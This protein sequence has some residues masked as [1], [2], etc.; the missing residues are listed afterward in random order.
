MSQILTKDSRVVFARGFLNTISDG[1]ANVYLTISHV[2]PWANE[3]NPDIPIDTVD[4]QVGL[5]RGMIGGK[6]ITG[7]DIQLVVPRYDWT[8][9]TV[10][11]SYTNSANAS[12]ASIFGS[13]FY[14]LTSDFNVYKCLGN[15]GNANSTVMPTYTAV[16]RSHTESDGYVWKYMLS[17]TTLDRQKFLTTSYFPVRKLLL[18]DG[19]LQWR[20]QGA[21]IAGTVDGVVLTNNGSN[22]TN[23]SNLVVTITGDGSSVTATG[24]INV[25]SQTVNSIT[26][27]SPGSGFHFANVSIT[28]GGGANATGNVVVSPISGHGVDAPAE[29]GASTIMINV[30]LKNSESGK[31]T[32]N[33]DYHKLGLIK[34]PTTFGTA[35]QIANSVFSQTYG[36]QVGFGSGDYLLDEYVFQGTGLGTATYSGRVVDWDSS[37]SVISLTETVGTISSAIITGLTS[38]ASRFVIQIT[39]PDVKPYSGDVLYI[40]NVTPIQRS[41]NQT[42]SISTLIQF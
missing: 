14:V 37:N 18:N 41:I 8:A 29:L 17:L 15:N 27:T 25:T 35:N 30:L 23:V 26:I 1:S 40:E 34:A 4:E 5:W 19:S 3:S 10:Y 6:R 16:D 42:E 7:N 39:N 13:S 33:N 12:N 36:V 21:A 31:L 11:T 28:G 24:N 32:T 38:G 9:N 20:V 2:G 22:Y